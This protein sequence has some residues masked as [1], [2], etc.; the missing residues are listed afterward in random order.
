[1]P[2]NYVTIDLGGP[3][4]NRF[5]FVPSAAVSNAI[6]TNFP[7]PPSQAFGFE[8]SSP[9][10][11]RN[12]LSIDIAEPQTACS[13][14]WVMELWFRVCC[15]HTDPDTVMRTFATDSG[16]LVEITPTAN[17]VVG[18][19]DVHYTTLDNVKFTFNAGG[20]Y[21]YL[22]T[23]KPYFD[24][25]VRTTMTKSGSV[26]AALAMKDSA[27]KEVIELWWDGESAAN[28]NA[29]GRVLALPGEEQ[30]PNTV[31]S[32]GD[33][34]IEEA[35]FGRF[36]IVFNRVEKMMVVV[37]S[38]WGQD[39]EVKAH[40]GGRASFYLKVPKE[41][42]TE[43][44]AGSR[45]DNQLDDLCYREK[46]RDGCLSLN[47]TS[48]QV[49]DF[50]LSWKATPHELLFEK[51]MTVQPDELKFKKLSVTA[52]KLEQAS[53]ICLGDQLCAF[54]FI[55]TGDA[56]FARHTLHDNLVHSFKKFVYVGDALV[57]TA[58]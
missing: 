15:D 30:L 8:T 46:S 2:E 55:S 23:K 42:E 26:L 18:C 21:I 50:G 47:A 7:P 58:A 29:N 39:F 32:F 19:G 17:V 51:W 36:R 43:G 5:N 34:P 24:F 49:H 56:E 33:N 53:Q 12:S 31:V 10:T 25:H 44:L 48:A 13:T 27:T 38:A 1:M 9:V 28:M 45:N 14:G 54:D 40:Y 4:S 20:D 11:L 52:E 22:R 57:P 37:N 3:P 35:Q 16:Q 41:W 6:S